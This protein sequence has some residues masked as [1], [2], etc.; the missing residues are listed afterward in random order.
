MKRMIIEELLLYLNNEN[1]N[2]SDM[3]MY[4]SQL[5]Q[6]VD[7]NVIGSASTLLFNMFCYI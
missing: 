2:L 1:E 3:K 5:E 4:K 6:I 7:N